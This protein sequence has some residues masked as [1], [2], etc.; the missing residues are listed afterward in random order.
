MLALQHHGVE[1][2]SGEVVV[3]GASG[4]V[5]SIAV[6]LLGQLGYRVVAVTGKP[7][8]VD[9]LR[10]W[11]AADIASR[12]AVVDDSVKPLLSARWGGAVDTVG[13]GRS[14]RWC[15]RQSSGAVWRRVA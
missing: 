14:V 11:G 5:G 2:T 13:G 9:R 4:G 1:P 6:M 12:D 7:D 15:A 3:T 8:A 10:R